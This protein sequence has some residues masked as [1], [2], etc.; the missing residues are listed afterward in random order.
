MTQKNFLYDLTT[1]GE[2]MLRLSVPTGTRL[3]NARQ[4]DVSAGGAESNVAGALAQLGWRVGWFSSLPDQPLGHLL[5][6][7]MQKVGVDV[8]VGWKSTGR[9]GTYFIEFA[10]PPRTSQ[11][12]YDRAESCASQM[13][14]DDVNLEQLLNTRWLHLTGITPALSS[15]CQALIHTLFTQ[16]TERGIK[17]SFD[18]NYRARLWSPS[19]ARTTCLALA[20][21]VDL[22]FCSLRDAHTV[23]EIQGTPEHC[24]EQLQK[25]THAKQIVMS[26]GDQGAVFFDGEKQHHRPAVKTQIIDRI[27]AGD[28]LAAGVLHGILSDGS[29]RALD[30]GVMMAALALSQHGDMVTT[31]RAELDQLIQLQGTSSSVYR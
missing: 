2:T 26:M 12:V 25:I 5:V 1:L 27:G 24:I 15:S 13:T 20:Q 28:A 18:V 4:F 11:V 7:P 6:S 19:E 30:C 23:F 21:N 9:V 10:A 16:A 29:E 17:R 31:S 14:I 3:Q 8:Q 22:L